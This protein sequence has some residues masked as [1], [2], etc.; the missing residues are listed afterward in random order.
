MTPK[1]ALEEDRGP[2]LVREDPAPIQRGRPPKVDHDA[3]RIRYELQETPGQWFLLF[4]DAKSGG[5]SGLLR[6]LCGRKVERS[7]KEQVEYEVTSRRNSPPEQTFR[8]Y[9]RFVGENGEFR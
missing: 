5:C 8:I 2:I 6:R 9:A 7:Q 3:E 4:D 1:K